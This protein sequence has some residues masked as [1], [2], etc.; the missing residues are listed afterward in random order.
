MRAAWLL[1]A[2]LVVAGAPALADPKADALAKMG[3]KLLGEKKF[4]EA[5][6]AFEEANSL[7]ATVASKLAVAHCYEDWGKLATALTWFR[8]AEKAATDAKSKDAAKIHEHAQA[9]DD[10]T[11]RLTLHVGKD[12]DVE[13]GNVTLD[14]T[15]V[16]QL[17]EPIAVD[18]GTHV[19]EFTTD[20]GERKKKSVPLERGGSS[21]VKLDLPKHKAG[22]D[23]G[24][25]RKDPDD[26]TPV[27]G[28]SDDPGKQQRLAAYIIG[29]VGVAAMGSAVYLTID[30]RHDYKHA[31][32]ADCGGR[33]DQC[34]TLGLSIT[35]KARTQANIATVVGSLGAVAVAGAVY[36]YLSAPKAS[37]EKLTLA[38]TATPDGVGVV[39]FGRF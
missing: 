31:L 35:H 9:L 20:G 26:H 17:G 10:D 21:D 28:K 32:S 23:D 6:A 5:C 7:G 24:H 29:G 19:V 11:P 27:A 4:A 34:N 15:P 38:P 14:G 16:K 2:G 37:R 3:K 25:D 30:A 39:V 12:V 8:D 13:A 22:H 1:A 33:S 36:L 18:P